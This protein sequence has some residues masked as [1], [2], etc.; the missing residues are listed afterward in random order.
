[1]RLLLDTHILLWAMTKPKILSPLGRRLLGDDRNELYF[2]AVNIFE[3]ASKRA[4]GSRSAPATAAD[5][6]YR[7]ALKA[8]I[9]ELPVRAE[10]AMIVETL[11]I[12][13]PDPFDRLLL[14]QAKFEGMQLLTHDES[15]ARHDPTAILVA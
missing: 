11:A 9:V 15:L 7:L 3:I 8:D 14:A 4:S 1:M 10:H 13:H 6:I 5:A 2:S 12:S